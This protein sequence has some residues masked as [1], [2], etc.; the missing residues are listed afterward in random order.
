MKLNDNN[1]NKSASCESALSIKDCVSREMSE[2]E[3]RTTRVPASN[4]SKTSGGKNLAWVVGDRP[5]RTPEE[6]AKRLAFFEARLAA[7]RNPANCPKCGKL[8]DLA[9]KMCQRCIATQ[10]KRVAR[11]RGNLPANHV[12][13]PAQLTKVVAQVRR[14]MTAMQTRFKLWQKAVNYKRS[15]KYRTDTI[16]RKYFSPVS[17]DVAADYLAKTNHAYANE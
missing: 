3:E 5:S 11:E 4:P 15:L 10:R 8:R 14:E 13:S 7:R 16:R 6:V 9:G 2:R 17:A 12:Y 1:K